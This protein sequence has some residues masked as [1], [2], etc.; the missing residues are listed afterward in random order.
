MAYVRKKNPL[1]IERLIERDKLW[2]LYGK[3]D[4]KQSIRHKYTEHKNNA[5]KRGIEFN[6]TIEE[7]WN[8]WNASGRWAQRGIGDPSKYV[9][10]RNND[11]GAYEVGNV[12]I[13]L[14]GDNARDMYKFRVNNI[15]GYSTHPKTP[16]RHQAIF[17]GKKLGTFDSPEE[18]KQAYLKARF[19]Y[20]NPKLGE[21]K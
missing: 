17:M 19:E 9:M 8:I 6:L 21:T 15:K 12:Y 11:S 13:T 4:D 14:C 3:A 7:W 10:A 1:L 16:N 20:E 18:A 5:K 2:A